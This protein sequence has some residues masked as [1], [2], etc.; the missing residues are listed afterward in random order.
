MLQINWDMNKEINETELSPKLDPNMYEG[1]EYNSQ[2][3][4][5]IE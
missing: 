1:L 2:D 3:F 5:S 4:K